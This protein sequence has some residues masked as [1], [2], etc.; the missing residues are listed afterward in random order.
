MI[1]RP[2]PLLIAELTGK[3][4]LVQMLR[5]DAIERSDP[6]AQEAESLAHQ[7]PHLFVHQV[8]PVLIRVIRIARDRLTQKI[9]VVHVGEAF[10]Q[11]LPKTIV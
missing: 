8:P 6:F 5:D 9:Q 7:G 4:A 10:A 11:R 2:D 3:N 1:N